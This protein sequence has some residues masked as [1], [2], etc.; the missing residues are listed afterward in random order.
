MVTFLMVTTPVRVALNESF[1]L[2]PAVDDW[3]ENDP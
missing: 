1:S 3:T 2:E